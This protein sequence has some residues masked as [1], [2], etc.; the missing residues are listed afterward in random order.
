[1]DMYC[2]VGVQEEVL[3]DHE[4]KLT[5]DYMKKVSRLLSIGRLT[6]SPY[7]SA[8]SELIEKFNVML[9]QILRRLCHEQSR[10]WH[11]FIK[12]VLIAAYR[13]VQQE[14]SRFSYFDMR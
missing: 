5:S 1:M 11:H 4:T 3:N 2:W 12:P 9:K 14:N 13:V 6:T 8:C 7:H 10:Q